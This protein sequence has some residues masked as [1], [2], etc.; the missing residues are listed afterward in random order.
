MT[1]GKKEESAKLVP[2]KDVEAGDSGGENDQASSEP[3]QTCSQKCLRFWRCIFG[4]LLFPVVFI[5]TF[6][7]ALVWC[8]L[9]PR[10]SN[11]L[12]RRFYDLGF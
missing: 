10:K 6:V 1:L 9:L 4:F 5:L 11:H 3:E 8:L 2:G 7:A 12:S